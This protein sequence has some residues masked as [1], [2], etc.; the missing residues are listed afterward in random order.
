MRTDIFIDQERI[1]LRVRLLDAF[2]DF[3]KVT[4]LSVN[5]LLLF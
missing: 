2:V 3:K 5:V 4:G 1:L